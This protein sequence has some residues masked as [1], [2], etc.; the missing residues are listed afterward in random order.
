M[1]TFLLSFFLVVGCYAQDTLYTSVLYDNQM[2]F[3]KSFETTVAQTN[4]GSVEINDKVVWRFSFPDTGVYFANLYVQSFI[5]GVGIVEDSLKLVFRVETPV[6]NI[7]E[8]RLGEKTPF[9]VV[10]PGLYNLDGYSCD[11]VRPGEPY[12]LLD[13]FNGPYAYVKPDRLG[14]V[15][16]RPLYH[17]KP[18]IIQNGVVVEEVVVPVTFSEK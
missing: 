14:Y 13:G 4:I 11:V 16:I 17:G 2:E 18:Y 6:W 1:K 8:V 10:V 7:P 3:P 15:K 12:N 5:P 9:S